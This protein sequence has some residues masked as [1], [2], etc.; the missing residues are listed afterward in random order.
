MKLLKK[1][2]LERLEASKKLEKEINKELA[3][4]KLADANFKVEIIPKEE[5]LWNLMGQRK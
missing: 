1:L 4:L 3:P 5:K 2:S